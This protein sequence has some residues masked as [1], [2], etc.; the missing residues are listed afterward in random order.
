M[1]LNKTS[2]TP[3]SDKKKKQLQA[4]ELLNII[5]LIILLLGFTCVWFGCYLKLKVLKKAE[6]SV[7]TTKRQTFIYGILVSARS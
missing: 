4:A 1:C 5:T 6:A 7:E 2:L 3:V